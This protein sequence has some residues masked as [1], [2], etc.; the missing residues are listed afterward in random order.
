MPS[1][2]RAAT[3]VV[4]HTCLTRDTCVNLIPSLCFILPIARAG[5]RSWVGQGEGRTQFV[6]EYGTCSEQTVHLQT[7]LNPSSTKRGAVTNSDDAT[8]S[9][10]QASRAV[11]LLALLAVASAIPTMNLPTEEPA[12]VV[13][14]VEDA[15]HADFVAWKTK[16]RYFALPRTNSPEPGRAPGGAGAGGCSGC[17]RCRRRCARSHATCRSLPAAQLGPA[18]PSCEQ[19]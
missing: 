8:R 10:M 15:L 17:R 19:Q 14:K 2:P 16:V 9:A 6:G 4:S 11:C 12:R 1:R 7:L 5:A 13:R 3:R 18:T